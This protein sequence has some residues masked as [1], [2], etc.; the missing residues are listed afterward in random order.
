MHGFRAQRLVGTSRLEITSGSE[1]VSGPPAPDFE[2]V[3]VWVGGFMRLQSIVTKSADLH[4]H[5][6]SIWQKRVQDRG[7]ENGNQR[8]PEPVIYAGGRRAGHCGSLFDRHPGDIK[9]QHSSNDAP[10]NF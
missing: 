5:Y 8:G 4:L 6:D 1:G 2:M 10:E 9:Y 3:S 7:A